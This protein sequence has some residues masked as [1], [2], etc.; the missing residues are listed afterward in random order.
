MRSIVPPPCLVRAILFSLVV[1]I[2]IPL[3]FPDAAF[4]GE[5]SVI[6]KYF[7]AS[8]LPNNKR[9]CDDRGLA[10]EEKQRIQLFVISMEIGWRV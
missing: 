1:I 9:P 5:I 10:G 4:G 6:R 3:R 2:A 8:G 7:T